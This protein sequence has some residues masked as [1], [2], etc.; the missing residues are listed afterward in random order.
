MIHLPA[1]APQHLVALKKANRVRLARA[2]LKRK[3]SAGEITAAS[4]LHDPP[5]EAETMTVFD[6]LTAQHRWGDHRARGILRVAQVPETKPVGR[7]T[8]RQR[9]HV[10]TLIEMNRAQLSEARATRHLEEWAIERNSRRA[11]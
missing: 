10:A 8:L 5:A 4:V 9:F 3:V 1:D 2:E 7:M 6:L 11:A